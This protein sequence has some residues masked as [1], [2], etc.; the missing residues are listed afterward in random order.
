[1]ER[2]T[3][4]LLMNLSKKY[5]FE[6]DK[7]FDIMWYPN[8]VLPDAWTGSMRTPMALQNNEHSLTRA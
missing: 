4:I 1:M 5:K 7:Y 2:L 6:R 8:V 3:I